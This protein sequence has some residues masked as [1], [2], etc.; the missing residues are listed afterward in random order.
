MTTLVFHSSTLGATEYAT[1]YRGL[2]GDYHI[3][4]DGAFHVEGED[5]AG[6]PIVSSFGMAPVNDGSRYKRRTERA[7]MQAVSEARFRCAVAT[8]T[9]TYTY[10]EEKRDGHN[11]RFIFGRGIR[12]SYLGFT[13]SNPD[14]E[15]F[16]I[17]AVEFI[18]SVSKQ[19]K[20]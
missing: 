18:D 3:T 11:R 10:D 12:D 2:A 9:A 15:P 19:R 6:E 14:G 1:D 13:F 17:D 5:D 16:L 8:P 4:A 7:Y 20:V